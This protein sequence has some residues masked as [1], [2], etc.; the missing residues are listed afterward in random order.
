LRAGVTCNEFG[1]GLLENGTSRAVVVVAMQ[2][3]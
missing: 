2:R 1:S 3:S